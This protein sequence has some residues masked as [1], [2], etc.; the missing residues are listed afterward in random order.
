M[1]VALIAILALIGAF[2]AEQ[3][4]FPL[5]GHGTRWQILIGLSMA[6]GVAVYVMVIDG[7]LF[8][9]VFSQP[10]LHPWVANPPLG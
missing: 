3:T 10:K 5:T 9:G 6:A 4:R 1:R 7:L 8:R 2:S